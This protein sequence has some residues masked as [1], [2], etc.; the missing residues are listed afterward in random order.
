MSAPDLSRFPNLTGTAGPAH[1][2]AC[3]RHVLEDLRVPEEIILLSF[4]ALLSSY[5]GND[6]VVFLTDELSTTKVVVSDLQITTFAG[7]P[8]VDGD[9]STHSGLFLKKAPGTPKL[10]FRLDYDSA[11]GRA[12]LFSSQ[13]IPTGYLQHL[14]PQLE[15]AVRA[16]CERK[17]LTCL[18][19]PDGHLSLSILNADPSRLPGPQFLHHLIQ[20][21]VERDGRTA[22][23]DY[24]DNR[25]LHHTLSYADFDHLSTRWARRISQSLLSRNAQAPAVIPVLVPQSPS[26]YVALLAVLK[27]GCAFCPL[28]LDAPPERLR[29][30]LN[31]VSAPLVMSTTALKDAFSSEEG[32][33]VLNMD[34]HPSDQD[35]AE[36]I[37][38]SG[39]QP[40]DLAYVMYT[41]GSTGTPKG[42]GVSHAA[43]T[44]SLLAHDRHIPPFSR[45]LQFAASTFDVSVFEIFFPFF[46]GSTLACADR[47]LLLGDL[48]AAMNA[49]KVDAAELTPT[50][51]GTLLRQRQD[52][53]SLQLLLTIGEMLTS[54]VVEEFGGS[55]H[56]DS[57]LWGMYGPTEAAIHCTLQPA[58]QSNMKVGNIGIPFDTVSAFVIRPASSNLNASD[59]ELLPIGQVGELAVGGHQLANGYLNRH[60]QTEAAFIQH[61]QFGRIYRTGDKARILPDGTIE[62]LGRIST[63]QVKLRG[64]R[65]ELGE[66][67]QVIS[68]VPGCRNVTVSVIAGILV[69][70]CLFDDIRSSASQDITS[71][72]QKWLPAFMV[73]GDVVV[74]GQLPHLPSGKVDRKQLEEDY[75][76]R[77]ED[78]HPDADVSS[79][80]VEREMQKILSDILQRPVNS[81]S[82]LA[83]LGLDSL[84]AIKAA[85]LL[86]QEGIEAG[87]VDL[88]SCFNIISLRSMIEERRRSPDESATDNSVQD[89]YHE[90]RA[91]ALKEDYLRD[92]QSELLDIISCTPLQ[93]SMLAET[94]VDPRAYCNWIEIGFPSGSSAS[95]VKEWIRRLADQNEI[96]RSGFL[97]I[98]SSSSAYAQ[99][100][101]KQLT[102]E[103]LV[104]TDSFERDY[105]LSSPSSLLRPFKVQIKADQMGTKALLQIPHYL[106]DGWS[107]DLILRKLADSVQNVERSKS[108]PQF[109]AVAHYYSK[110]QRSVDFQLSKDYWEEHMLDFQ[111]SPLPNFHGFVVDN[112]RLSSHRRLSKINPHA[113]K[114]KAREMGV[115]P[116]VFFQAALSYLLSLYVGTNDIVIGTVTSGRTIP[117]TGIETVLGPCI[118]TLPLRIDISQ[119]RKTTDLLQDIQSKNRRML[120]H[121]SVPLKDIKRACG[122][123]PGASLF[124]ALFI[125]QE[126]TESTASQDQS[127]VSL[128][129]SS[130]LLEF[131]L[132]VEIVPGAESL[133]IGVRHNTS[134][135]PQSQVELLVEQMDQL[136][137]MFVSKDEAL[138]ED[139]HETFDKKVLSVENSSPARHCPSHGLATHIERLSEQDPDRAAITFGTHFEKTRLHTQT[140]TYGQLNREAN[141]LAH[142]LLETVPESQDLICIC[143]EKSIDLYIAIVAVVKA[144]KGYL[145]LTVETPVERIRLILQD[146]GA[147]MILG[148][149]ST[150]E[151]LRSIENSIVVDVDTLDSPSFPDTNLDLPY[152]GSNLAYAVFTSGS[153]GIPK[154]VLVTQ[155]NLGSNLMA[156][157]AIYP[158]RDDSRLLQSCS[159]AFD[160]SVFEIF[161]AFNTGM[162]LCSATNDVLF[163][164]LEDA[165]RQLE[166]T[167]LSLTPTIAALVDPKTVPTVSFLVT[168]GEAVT[169]KVMKTWAN[170][171]L[172]Q[173][174]GP[175][176][177]TNICTVQPRVESY[178]LISNIGKPLKNTSA[179]VFDAEGTQLLP[180][181]AVGELCFGG[182]Q[183][184]RG[185]LNRSDLNCGRFVEHPEYGRIY[186]SGDLGRLLPDGSIVFA[187]R[188][189]DQV[190]IRGQRVELGEINSRILD[191]PSVHDCVTLCI[192][193]R[194]S[195]GSRLTSFYVPEGADAQQCSRMDLN[196]KLS[197]MSDSIFDHL[198]ATL[199]T[200]M[201]PNNII[202]VSKIPSTT[203][204][205][206]DKRAL[207]SL[208]K[209]L[210]SAYLNMVAKRDNNDEE[211]GEL[212]GQE[213]TDIQ[214]Q[215]RSAV[216]EVLKI[217]P[218]DVRQTSSFFSLGL[219]SVSA[220]TLAKMIRE[221]TKIPAPV[222]VVLRNPTVMR[223]SRELTKANNHGR[224]LETPG[225]PTE[226]FPPST[227]SEIRSKFQ[228]AGK[229]IQKILPC[230]PLQ[231]AMLS[232]S[233]TKN[234][235]TYSNRMVLKVNG[236]LKRVLGAW[237]ETAK[238]H[239]V[240][241]TSFVDTDVA[242]YPY[243]QI[244]LV[245]FPALTLSADLRTRAQETN[246]HSNDSIAAK[247]S[248]LAPPW[249]VESAEDGDISS[250]IFSCHHALYDGAAMSA[251]LGE[252]QHLYKGG[253]LSPSI[254]YEPFLEQMLQCRSDEALN[255]WRNSVEGFVP[256]FL[257]STSGSEQQLDTQQLAAIQREVL[258]L[259]LSALES[260]CKKLSTTLL[261]LAQC[262]WA[263]T[264]AICL[265]V[266]DVCFG[267]VVS[268]RAVPDGIE[269]L[270]APCFNTVP[271]RADL[272]SYRSNIELMK[273]LQDF[274]AESLAH[275]LTPLR[276]IQAVAP[277]GP[278]KLLDTLLLLQQS[279][280]ELDSEIWEL[281]EDSG[282]MD[283]PL[284]LE[285]VPDRTSDAL[286]L[287][288][289]SQRA[290]LSDHDASQIVEAFCRA[291]E[292]SVRYPSSNVLDVPGLSL[293]AKETCDRIRSA[294]QS[295]SASDVSTDDS[296]L[297]EA[298]WLDAELEVRE[299]FSKLSGVPS[300][301]IGR[302]TTIHQIGLDSISAIQ[303]AARLKARGFKLTALDIL[304]HR[305]CSG[306]AS[307]LNNDEPEIDGAIFNFAAFKLEFEAPVLHQRNLSKDNVETFLPCTPM[308]SGIIAQFLKSHGQ[309]YF[310]SIALKLRPSVSAE[311]FKEALRRVSE[312]HPI[313]RT[314]F[315]HVKHPQHAFTAIVY[316]ATFYGTS[317]SE[318]T[319]GDFDAVAKWH[320]EAAKDASESLHHPQWR[321]LLVESGG[322]LTA[323]ISLLHALY[324]A[325][326]LQLILDDVAA[327]CDDEQ[328]TLQ[329]IT[330]PILGSILAASVE[331]S[332]KQ[333]DFW[334]SAGKG[335]SISRFPNMTPLQSDA[336]ETLV[337]SKICSQRLSGIEK[338][339][340]EANA[341]LQAA[342]QVAWARLL[343]SYLGEGTATFGVVLSGRTSTEDERV[344]FPCITTV[345]FSCNVQAD[346]RS[347]LEYATSF[348]SSVWRHQFTPLTKIQRFMGYAGIPLFDTIF[349]Y[350][351]TSSES[352]RTH[353]WDLVDEAATADY[354]I[355][356]EFEPSQQDELHMRITFSS[357]RLPKQQAALMLDQ[358]DSILLE[359]VTNID[360]QYTPPYDRNPHLFSVLPPK[361]PEIPS[362]VGLLHEFVEISARSHPDKVALQFTTTFDNQSGGTREWSYRELDH[363]GNR[364]AHLLQDRDVQPGEIVAVCF[365]KSPEASFAMLGILKAGCSFVAIDPSAPEARKS[366][367]LNDS[368]ASVLLTMTDVYGNDK[369]SST[370]VPVVKLET[371]NL[372]ALSP[373]PVKLSRP[374]SLQDRSYCL[375]TSGTTGTPKGCELTHENAVQ[376]MLSF[377]RLFAGHWDDESRW[378]QFASFHFDVSVLEQYWSWSVG[379]RVVS[380]PRDLIFEDLIL[381][382][383]ELGITHIDLTPSLARLLSPE[384]APSLCK[385]VF[386][387]GGEQLKQEILDSWGPKGVIYNGYGPTEA[388][389]G[390]TMYPRVPMNGKPSNIGPQF[391]NVGSFVLRPGTDEPVYRGAVGELCVSGKLVGK[392]YLNRPDLTEERFPVLKKFNERIY[393][394]GDLVR[395]LHD[396]C[397]DFLGRVDDQVKLRGQRLEIGEINSVIKEST[398]AISEVATLVVKHMKQS[399]EQLASFIVTMESPNPTRAQTCE[400]AANSDSISVAQDSCRGRLPGYMVPTYFIPIKTLPLSPNNK[401]DEKELKRFF[402]EL[403]LQD[404]QKLSNRGEGATEPATETEKKIINVLRSM[405]QVNGVEVSKNDSIF[406]LGLDSIS[407][408]GLSRNLKVA[409]FKNATASLIM[410]NST[411]DSLARALATSKDEIAANRRPITA[412]KQSSAAFRHRYLPVVV[413]TLNVKHSAIES[414]APC[415]PLQQGML[416]KALDDEKSYYFSAFRLNLPA[417]TDT[418]KLKTAWAT[419]FENVQILRS[420]FISTN[421]GYIQGVI[422]NQTLPWT[423]VL[424]A[425][426]EAMEQELSSSYHQWWSQ[427]HTSFERPFELVLVR[428]PERISLSLHMFHG[429]YDGNSL[430]LLLD[431]V[432]Q[433]YHDRITVDYGPT[434]HEVLPYGPLATLPDAREFWTPLL[435]Q[436][437]RGRMPSLI[438]TANPEPVSVAR[439]IS[440]PNFEST[441]RKLNATPQAVVQSC[442]AAVMQRLFSGAASFGLVVS[443]RSFD[444]DGVEKVIGPLF[445]TI[446]FHLGL[447][448]D[449]SWMNIVQRC[450]EFIGK[451]LAYQHTPLRD[452][453]KWT[454]STTEV[455]LFDTLF[456][457][458]RQGED[459]ADS[460]T[461]ELWQIEDSPPQL[462]Y[463]LAL[464]VE[465][466]TKGDFNLTLVAQGH[467]ADDTVA[468]ALLQD[469]EDALHAL[470]RDPESLISDTVGEIKEH[471]HSN[472]PQALKDH[473]FKTNGTNDTQ[474]SGS[475]LKIREEIAALVHADP[476]E[477]HQHVSILELGLDSIDAIKLSSR[478]ATTGLRIPVSQIMQ[479]LTIAKM[480]LVVEE[481]G[482]DSKAS[483][484][485]DLKSEESNLKS[486]F[487]STGRDLSDVESVYPTTP[488]Q[489]AMV[490]EMVNSSFGRYF[491]QDVLKLGKNTDLERLKQ[492]WEVVQ[493][494]SPVLRTT[495]V[496]VADA[497]I[498]YSFAQLVMKRGPLQW[499]NHACSTKEDLEGLINKRRHL[500]AD[501]H[502]QIPPFYLDVVNCG[503]DRFL[504]LSM[505]HALYDGW[506]I[507]L[508][509]EDVQD[510]YHNSLQQR[511]LYDEIL[512]DVLGSST[513]DAIEF[514]RDSL[515]GAQSTIFPNVDQ[516]LQSQE[517]LVYR[518]E[519]TSSCDGVEIKS[520]CKSQGIT[521]QALGQACWSAV[522]ASYTSQ[523]EVI[524]G[525]VLSGRD[526]EDANEILF[527]T[528]NTVAVRSFLHGSRSE[529]LQYTQDSIA[530]I[531]QYQHFPLRK[532]QAF[533]DTRGQAL[534]NTLF[535]YQAKPSVIAD[536][537]QQ[538]YESV[539]GTSEVEYPVCVEMELVEDALVWRAACS[540]TV[541]SASGTSTLLEKLDSVL[542]TIVESPDND[543]IQFQQEGI[544]LA[545]LPP[546]EDNGAATGESTDSD[547]LV[548]S[549]SEA[550]AWTETEETIREVLSS[551][552]KMN[553]DEIARTSTLFHLGL[554]SISAIKVAALLRKRGINFGVSEMLR[555]A[556]VQK[557]AQVVEAKHAVEGDSI[558]TQPDQSSSWSHDIDIDHVLSESRIDKSDV[559]QIAPACAGQVHMLSVWENSNGN[560]FYPTFKFRV[561]GTTDIDLVH[562]AWD[563][564]VS[565]N[566]ILRT[567][568]ATTQSEEYPIL[569][570]ITKKSCRNFYHLDRQVGATEEVGVN[571][572]FA[573]LGV[574]A[575]NFSLCLELKI[576]HALYDGVS[577]PLLTG[578]LQDECNKIQRSDP[579]HSAFVELLTATST[580]GLRKKREDFWTDYLSGTKKQCLAQQSNHCGRRSE[581]FRPGAVPEIRN[582]ETA[583]K[584]LGLS[585][586]SI[587]LAVYAR[588]YATLASNTSTSDDSPDVVFGIYLA[589]RSHAIDKLVKAPVPTVNLVPLRVTSPR[590][591]SLSTS[592]QQI[593]ADLLN[594]GSLENSSVSLWEIEKCTGIKLD[595][596]VNFLNLPDH[597]E[598]NERENEDVVAIRDANEIRLKPRSSL[599]DVSTKST[600]PKELEGNCVK[601]SYLQSLDIEATVRDGV[602]DVGVFS[603]VEMLGI[604]AAEELIGDLQ[605]E[606]KAFLEEST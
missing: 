171:G 478:L 38:A 547:T 37:D 307:L 224:G 468:N 140:M 40:A 550:D 494:S 316:K 569:Q 414:I 545:G 197:G 510:A 397:F 542:T 72:C 213:W 581:V 246:R 367:I 48:P 288:L 100:I 379:I 443:G 19:R 60:E 433:A 232:A 579:A 575:E 28:N 403:S 71:L 68:K 63:G 90:I 470:L 308:Q 599:V 413:R 406:E 151:F 202:P 251:F 372:A 125:W 268:G 245:D 178:H 165:I 537:K 153:T 141:R 339:C 447:R 501:A 564:L 194:N 598:E 269:R 590:T 75:R 485:V 106:Y 249:K 363:N 3:T 211:E 105:D 601:G 596:F 500:A 209:G 574:R 188:T 17:S 419:T 136:V 279:S 313:L 20:Q 474:W 285:L 191:L 343:A 145:P 329:P 18:D 371:K 437:P 181:G 300:S 115:N 521:L 107:V 130:D 572:P 594:I 155:N 348:N 283:L 493:R 497:S 314:G 458:Q 315:E 435:A 514:W 168:A 560:L 51:A 139:A 583:A 119:F 101:W 305:T 117:V 81:R 128:I 183:V 110:V 273:A 78:A 212:E 523:L 120:K 102:E 66:I 333:K 456:V 591:R 250:M 96:L 83:T 49:L 164:D 519:K 326:S 25:N 79:N 112:G 64:Q 280:Y 218:T 439:K 29:F 311:K 354:P 42:V 150:S 184:C 330:P 515:S 82:K 357:D 205:K 373:H 124:D 85:S 461:N 7:N 233:A 61:L 296:V 302:N 448:K 465:D 365:E 278:S 370:S 185:Y 170:N 565:N 351:K 16:M 322:T 361:D 226:V 444:I 199:T 306:I 175:S 332:D 546:F 489:E 261:A 452:I 421:D 256:K 580:S 540:N 122:L 323:H 14:A 134:I 394:T 427:N 23:I 530:G 490:A 477:I 126:T 541:L 26:L 196:D 376:A 518:K 467:I 210:D 488:L 390:V 220:I 396:G 111:P 562:S 248:A 203:Q 244:V 259:A 34:E 480:A 471:S 304:E 182:E 417:G 522:L 466:L 236:E 319:G 505:A 129:D 91:S 388:T 378:L 108:V 281:K 276:R 260:S 240:F 355:S 217:S 337:V 257:P 243:A 528:M 399:K 221:A 193:N 325:H 109:R 534:F 12:T 290:I 74:L 214:K 137:E 287:T 152:T 436:S 225:R 177:T 35:L 148:R 389:I 227:L 463:P 392:G 442:W 27:T 22:A 496:E 344:A 65:I 223:L 555:A 449:D 567:V 13:Q 47:T 31:D 495:F 207:V 460:G 39:A 301:R 604:E 176:E 160:V 476:Q 59:I 349:A 86:R 87:A 73:P 299:V 297:D 415:T 272:E 237:I 200:Y 538:L 55:A 215:I 368:G 167:H 334:E 517:T 84:R 94:A 201:I 258:P 424:A 147:N 340:R 166:I 169:E 266:P 432:A 556:T 364:I 527:P 438:P 57:V 472:D 603:P 186:R 535:I 158:H 133:E 398:S 445:N 504:I 270:M 507:G 543:M 253:S 331:K 566:P 309:F 154:G 121:C 532:A 499:T 10:A 127:D 375:Y 156:L 428:S 558:A 36:C 262:A 56:T 407:A 531:R 294:S 570:L 420:R 602:L 584:R 563:C 425:S 222:S 577:L 52:V 230:T 430:P 24:L 450:Q 99:V 53:P 524:F 459:I 1:C 318:V 553:E 526:S 104:D 358:L 157:S 360:G 159:Q 338:H 380:A 190:K 239:E 341:S 4:A 544:S 557:M 8:T 67:E 405:P 6:E 347:L 412:A 492:A 293:K 275:N 123:Q 589:N 455:P 356:I 595:S 486:F 189:D 362:S 58:F 32:L 350:Q 163:H 114:E 411:I 92:N 30:I 195:H 491:N 161:F 597:S 387:T 46:R 77:M 267:N 529:M 291:L 395:M 235:D 89:F 88:L 573:C 457:F 43:A 69:A 282:E 571:Q 606:M 216:S 513:V 346:N 336:Q 508:L 552:A 146:A 359:L 138:L 252:V 576:H 21:G 204:G 255:F 33:L 113:L 180:R 149:S 312:T 386:I 324:D 298:S 70:F 377:Q 118:A 50:V 502:L 174:Y 328:I 402:S 317:V 103:A 509:H 511:P 95:N 219:D 585:V 484:K 423:E 593:Q 295:A 303:V 289:H 366:F 586:H 97:A 263:K 76:C 384:D 462:D 516:K 549:E 506:S 352:G 116:Q 353:P 520:F 284:V 242:E 241:R 416:S 473:S 135:L 512:Q 310:N 345:P 342:G 264:L 277:N 179:F 131:K 588:V 11:R 418:D 429:L 453:M 5:T 481:A 451:V 234:S 592:A 335:A 265:G 228:A 132:T 381:A 172:Y 41:S 45:F 401:V 206:V 9:Y 559:E 292:S 2:A 454:N 320:A 464:E 554:D 385:G 469:F 587:F 393:R 479:C 434:F 383:R 426:E 408:I 208:F 391:D 192:D 475:A 404:L 539:G 525:V 231:E 374:I 80:P 422:R 503:G 548:D 93:L 600:V 254:S 143:M 487:R 568:F 582:Y 410:K 483:T 533:A 15:A 62:C 187:G 173:G 441:R 229:R 162:C 54:T 274:N 238:S 98:R 551:V 605:K 400:L 578:Q 44:Q 198:S 286:R 440:A 247:L 536:D 144:G 369:G 327:A 142:H 561:N 482:T 446:P 382:I 431:A 271:I 321:V 409:G 498:S